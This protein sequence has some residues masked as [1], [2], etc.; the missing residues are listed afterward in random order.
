MKS[1]QA[2]C[3]VECAPY[4]SLQRC[5]QP[6]QKSVATSSTVCR[7][8]YWA[9]S[10]SVGEASNPGPPYD[11]FDDP[12]GHDDWGTLLQ[13][14]PC[15]IPCVLPP[16]PPACSLSH[17]CRFPDGT[18]PSQ[19]VGAPS[20]PAIPRTD[21]P[22]E[23]MHSCIND[24]A[25]ID[26]LSTVSCDGPPNEALLL[27]PPSPTAHLQQPVASDHLLLAAPPTPAAIAQAQPLQFMPAK[28]FLG[29]KQNMVFKLGPHGI[30][31]YRDNGV[32]L[33]RHGD[34]GLLRSP[35]RTAAP[36]SLAALVPPSPTGDP[37]LADLVQNVNVQHARLAPSCPLPRRTRARRRGRGDAAPTTRGLPFALCEEV[38]AA[39]VSH[40]AHGLWAVDSVNPN[41]WDATVK[42]IERTSADILALQETRRSPDQIDSAVRVAA[43]KRWNLS[44]AAAVVNESTRCSAGVGVGARSHLGVACCSTATAPDPRL[45]ARCHSRW[46]GAMCRG[47]LHVVSL[48]L[49]TAE[50]LSQRNLDLLQA[51]AE[52]LHSLNGPWVVAAD[53]NLPPSELETS[54]WLDFVGAIVVSTKLPT[55][56]GNR[57]DYFA[58]SECLSHAVVGASVVHDAGFT[59]HRPVRMFLRAAPREIMLRRLVAPR[60]FLVD[61]PVGCLLATAHASA[62]GFASDSDQRGL[63]AMHTNWLSAVEADLSGI[64][65]HTP[66]DAGFFAGRASGPRLKWTPAL[67]TVGAP[68]A[69]SSA[70]SRAWRA[71]ACHCSS[72]RA[73]AEHVSDGRTPPPGKALAA[74]A[75]ARHISRMAAHHADATD[76]GAGTTCAIDMA[77]M[78]AAARAA[79]ASMHSV[80]ALRHVEA[81]ASDHAVRLETTLADIRRKQWLEWIKGGPASGL[82]RQHKFTRTTHGWVP[83]RVGVPP[84]AHPRDSDA[85][86][87]NS[88]TATSRIAQAASGPARPL[89]AQ[90]VV[91]A[92]ADEW[93]KHWGSD[94]QPPNIEWPSDL[95]PM[96]A[97][98]TV[99]RL[100]RVL[101]TFP[102]RT[103]LSW[104]ALHP[105]IL[106]RLSDTRLEELIDVLMAAEAEGRWPETLAFISI[107][108]LPKATG[109]FRPI[110]LFPTIVRIWMRLRRDMVDAWEADNSRDFF[111]A[112]RQRGAHVAAWTQAARAEAAALGGASF[113]QVLIDLAKCFEL[114]PHDILAREAAAVGYPLPLLRMSLAAYRLPRSLAIHGVYSSTVLAQRGIT[115]GSG[116]AT[117]ELRV[118]LIRL[119][120][121]VSKAYPVVLNVYVDD[122]SV[123]ATGTPASVVGSVAGAGS[124]LCHGL[125]ALRLKLSAAGKCTCTASTA[126][127]GNQLAD[128]LSAFGI[129]YSARVKALGVGMASGVRRNVQVQTGRLTAFRAKLSKFAALARSCISAARLFRTGGAAS[130]TYGDD[131]TGVSAETLLKR[132]RMVASAFAPPTGGR[133]LDLALLLADSS[134]RQHL[135]PAFAAAALPIGRW[136]EAVYAGWCPAPLLHAS[137]AHAKRRIL[138][139]WR[140]WALV[141]GLAAAT[142]ASAQRIGW[143]VHDAASMTTDLGMR[144]DL[145]LDSPSF[146]CAEVHASVTRWRLRNIEAN[147]P[148][149]RNEISHTQTDDRSR[150]SATTCMGLAIAPVRKLLQVASRTKEWTAAH[151]AALW[152]AVVNTQWPQARLHAAGMVEQPDCQLC[153]AAGIV[154]SAANP[155]SLLAEPPRGTLLHR[156]TAC[157]PTLDGLAATAPALLDGFTR[158]RNRLR[159]R[160]GLPPDALPSTPTP[161][162]SSPS[163]SPSIAAGAD[164]GNSNVGA[165]PP[166]WGSSCRQPELWEKEIPQRDRRNTI[167]ASA[168]DAAWNRASA[169][170]AATRALVPLP[171]VPTPPILPEGTYSWHG[172]PLRSCT[173]AT[174]YTDGPLIDRELH[175]CT[176]LGWAFIAIDDDGERIA[177][178]SGIPPPWIK[179]ISGAEAWALLMAAR[180]A[181]PGSRYITDSLNCVD[182]VR[183]G[184]IGHLRYAGLLREYGARCSA[185][186]I[187]TSKRART[188]PMS[189]GCLL[190]LRPPALD[191]TKR[192]TTRG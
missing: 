92:E 94:T 56:G 106:A 143:E 89:S 8:N 102:A 42:Y 20:V 75:A 93:A 2:H 62:A 27:P 164:A 12:E 51:L 76:R 174:F 137:M 191:A 167:A 7:T 98:P 116:M 22:F 177:A 107:V 17:P 83:T 122:M 41:A 183:R 141:C 26:D 120:E 126:A 166:L 85:R 105:R 181:A 5:D 103:G 160:F 25:S 186:G 71:L 52:H 16:S 163:P 21:S 57:N 139:T 136:A 43:A 6:L 155:R 171:H 100:R 61:L 149:L 13:D 59:P 170:A 29:Q 53:W 45:S 96:P 73:S 18:L 72:V 132:R 144:L 125:V 157:R 153:A 4:A 134:E 60:P 161:S 3:R 84:H 145:T 36:I 184:K 146:V 78:A 19:H 129:T 58:V 114:V 115:A 95:G 104:E 79:A 158:I 47:G 99:H 169:A 44:L 40:R 32:G 189:F 178:A 81:L 173:A 124:L 33:S 68:N 108:L 101:R 49:H 147:H 172:N 182:A 154:H 190:T 69:H 55:C 77:N 24:L 187:P 175:G 48:Y 34:P 86:C 165:P 28:R 119:L 11:P 39:D 38:E 152:S 74:Q 70:A 156:L 128:K 97:R 31:Y 112:G 130:F 37:C 138:S 87:E 109:G 65:S 117:T 168:Y 179:S 180:A 148:H 88:Q 46:V 142:V 159:A 80:P 66:A 91:E 118:L 10:C 110:G 176:R 192:A 127:I 131:V 30:G 67:G 123:E 23:G 63:E 151:Q 150:Y 9:S 135:D 35:T 121:R 15:H 188:K 140:P 111:Y 185:S 1:S 64:C 133:D 90:E 14:E 82:G 162:P 50:G 113:A 54:G